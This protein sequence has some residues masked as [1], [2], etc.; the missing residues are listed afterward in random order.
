MPFYQ[1]DQIRYYAFDSL[2]EFPLDQ[3]VFTR[4][5]GVSPAPWASLNMGGTV[6]DDPELVKRN[7]ELA[8]NV[9]HRSPN[10]VFD[11]F[12]V[13]SADVVCSDV[14]RPASEPHQRADIILT[15]QPGLTL[16]MRFAD[17]V[18]IMLFD[19][20]QHV[21]GLVH[22]GW[23]GTL[24]KAVNAAVQAM[25]TRYGSRPREIR[26]AIGPSIGPDHYE[27]GAD[28]V[29]QANQVFGEQAV[30]LLPVMNNRVHFDLWGANRL[31]LEMAGVEQIEVAG[32]CTACHLEDWFSHRAEHGKTGRFGALIGLKR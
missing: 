32:V 10:S 31:L 2:A 20:G 8:L 23:V 14:P 19:P 26:A 12:Q 21:V 13:H 1:P 4:R 6:G 22:A 18:P 30:S 27:V 3:A 28:V 24:K 9:F 5:G 7:K 11:V 29:T 25:Q 16:M 15:D 17:C